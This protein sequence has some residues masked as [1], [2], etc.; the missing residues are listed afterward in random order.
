MKYLVKN[1][2]VR[3]DEACNPNCPGRDCLCP[4]DYIGCTNLAYCPFPDGVKTMP[5]R[6]KQ[7]K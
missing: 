4:Y 7:A 1:K 2:T 5:G 3:T 6:K